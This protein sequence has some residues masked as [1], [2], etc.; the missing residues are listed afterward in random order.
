MDSIFRNIYLGVVEQKDS[1]QI[2]FFYRQPCCPCLQ[3]LLPRQRVEDDQ[4]EVL[5]EGIVVELLNQELELLRHDGNSEFG[6][7]GL[8]VQSV[9]GAREIRVRR[10]VCKG[11]EREREINLDDRGRSVGQE[12]L[13]IF[14]FLS[15]RSY[16]G[17]PCVR[18]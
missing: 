15:L 16:V 5:L 2:R 17:F 8:Q 6:E 4:V 9:L 14:L 1:D 18:V 10:H 7:V 13:Q 3:Q 11:R 12:G